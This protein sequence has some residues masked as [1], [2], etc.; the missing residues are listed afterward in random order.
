M[1]QFILKPGRGKTITKKNATM[2]F[3]NEEEQLYLETG[4]F[5]IGLGASLLQVRNIIDFP[6]NDT[7]DNATQFPVAFAS[8][9]LTSAETHAA[10]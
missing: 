6:S 1:E 5:G 9:S 2:A 7:S 3:Y 10:T 8:K 4:M